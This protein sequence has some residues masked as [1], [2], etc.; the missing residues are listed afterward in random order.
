M[1]LRRGEGKRLCRFLPFVFRETNDSQFLL[2]VVMGPDLDLNKDEVEMV[3]LNDF[4][5]V[6]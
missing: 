4:G 1:F 6:P 5:P 2:K 3:V